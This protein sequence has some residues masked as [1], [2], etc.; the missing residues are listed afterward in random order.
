MSTTN[1]LPRLPR[2]YRARNLL[3]W[4]TGFSVLV[5]VAA[6][7]GWFAFDP[8]IRAMFTWF[9][10][11]TLIIIGG[12]LIAF[13]MGLGMSIVRAD[14]EG[15]LIR[16]AMSV[17]RIAW[18]DIAGFQYRHGDPW[19]FVVLAGTDDMSPVGALAEHDDLVRRQMIGI[20][21]TDGERSRQ[22]VRELQAL[23][24]RFNG[25]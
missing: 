6:L 24:A 2:T 3:I 14:S 23:H 19:A 4:S 17:R 11:G 13:M 21:T 22:A 7:V 1:G 8:E 10:I 9:Q 5:V 16:N 18:S 12:V 15:I 25:G 20:Q